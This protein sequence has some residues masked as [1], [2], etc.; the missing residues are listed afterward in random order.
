MPECPYC[1]EEK[2]SR[3]FAVHKKNCSENPD[4]L[5]KEK[6][7]D[8]TGIKNNPEGSAK[9]NLNLEKRV[10]ALETKLNSSDEDFDEAMDDVFVRIEAL[11]KP[12]AE[13]L[14]DEKEPE[15][16]CTSCGGK[17]NELIKHCPHCGK[18]LDVKTNSEEIL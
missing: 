9:A 5:H 14:D 12:K 17:F 2:S 10:L 8:D 1:H 18:Q 11:E 7:K 3:G 13:I 16:E 6:F 4:R 15:W